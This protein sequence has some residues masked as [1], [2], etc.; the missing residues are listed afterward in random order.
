MPPA[1]SRRPSHTFYALAPLSP[2]EEQQ[3]F[4][5]WRAGDDSQLDRLLRANLGF[6]IQTAQFYAGQG[7]DLDDLIQEGLLGLLDAAGHFDETKGYKFITYAVYYL[8]RNFNQALDKYHSL[9]RIPSRKRGTPETA[10]HFR[11]L[12][13]PRFS[14]PEGEKEGKFSLNNSLALSVGPA[15]NSE[16]NELRHQVR[17]LLQALEPREQQ[18]LWLYYGF[19]QEPLLL[20]RIGEELQISREWVR[21]I[22]DGAIEKLREALGREPNTMRELLL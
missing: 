12:Q 15:E 10:L 7:V 6:V 22:R 14:S 17:K 11:S 16:G 19:G 21:Q 20:E 5:A 3:A 8:R 4:A 9:I 13:E 1:E 18:I 2:A